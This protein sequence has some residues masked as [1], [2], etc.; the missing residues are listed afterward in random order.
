MRTPGNL[1]KH[2]PT[3]LRHHTTVFTWKENLVVVNLTSEIIWQAT[4]AICHARS[5]PCRRP[6]E[7]PGEARLV[8]ATHR[9]SP[10]GTGR[11]ITVVPLKRMSA[12][13]KPRSQTQSQRHHS[14]A[15]RGRA[16]GLA[17]RADSRR[18]P[19]RG[20]PEIPRGREP[21]P[22]PSPPERV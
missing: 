18:R 13:A 14:E 22:P 20:A 6:S 10:T 7:R 16:A 17:R 21:G 4:D 5:H 1:A 11:T 19:T 2:A 12:F 9:A 8:P 15:K 3:E